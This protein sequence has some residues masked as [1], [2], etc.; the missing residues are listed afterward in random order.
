A[1]IDGAALP[2][3]ADVAAIDAAQARLGVALPDDLAALYRAHDGVPMFDFVP[4]AAVVRRRETVPAMQ[5]TIEVRLLD[6]DGGFVEPPHVVSGERAAEWLVL[7]TLDEGG[8]FHAYD[9]GEPPAVPGHRFVQ[10]FSGFAVAHP[11]LRAWLEEQ[12][13]SRQQY[14]AIA[15]Q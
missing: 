6:A 8:F 7:T 1:R 4:L 12:W 5:A 13:I 2:A 14:A 10:V 15:E 11:S 3:P 9:I